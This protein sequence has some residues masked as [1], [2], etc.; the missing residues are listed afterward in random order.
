MNT[1]FLNSW[2]YQN[3]RQ[4]RG[5][6]NG[7]VLAEIDPPGNPTRGVTVLPRVTK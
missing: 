7:P 6:R 4:G 2:W 1:R 5:F 3:E